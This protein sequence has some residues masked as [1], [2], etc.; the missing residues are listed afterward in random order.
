MTTHT[1]R[2]T[3]MQRSTSGFSLRHI[4][5]INTESDRSIIWPGTEPEAYLYRGQIFK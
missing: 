1:D 5:Y 3:K 4:Q 2:A